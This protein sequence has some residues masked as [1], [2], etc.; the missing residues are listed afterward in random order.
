MVYNITGNGTDCPEVDAGAT[1]L[2]VRL[3]MLTSH[4]VAK[5]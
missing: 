2:K 1:A 5:G 3:I 4:G